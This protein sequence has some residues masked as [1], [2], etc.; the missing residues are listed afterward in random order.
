VR[1]FGLI[2]FWLIVCCIGGALC[3]VFEDKYPRT[4]T[5]TKGEDM[6]NALLWSLIA[7]YIGKTLWP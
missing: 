3:V 2:F 7:V 5:R 4:T 6:G 1:T